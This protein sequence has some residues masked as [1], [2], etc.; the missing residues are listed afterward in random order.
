MN[1][2]DIVCVCPP[3][4]CTVKYRLLKKEK[5]YRR[6][7]QSIYQLTSVCFLWVSYC[8]TVRCS[9][10]FMFVAFKYLISFLDSVE[11]E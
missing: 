10:L 8:P 1:H 7:D 2:S 9:G 11:L 6:A 4:T 5:Q 3:G